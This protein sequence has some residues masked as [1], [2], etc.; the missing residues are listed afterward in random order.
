MKQITLVPVLLTNQ[1]LSRLSEEEKHFLFLITHLANE[2]S[3]LLKACL[4][5]N[6]A[7]LDEYE[8]GDVRRNAA[9]AQFYFF[10][11]ML[12]GKLYE[13]RTLVQKRYNGTTLRPR[14]E[15]NVEIGNTI[16]SI[17]SYFGPGD[18]IVQFIRHNY[19]NHNYDEGNYLLELL[20][21]VSVDCGYRFYDSENLGGRYNHASEELIIESIRHW[22]IEKHPGI[23]DVQRELLLELLNVARMFDRLSR[24]FLDACLGKILESSENE[25]QKIFE[26]LNIDVPN[27]ADIK[28][29]FF[30]ENS[31]LAETDV[32]TMRHWRVDG[33]GWG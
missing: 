5:T 11:R 29:P 26:E 25:M 30:S 3:M 7:V 18:S 2:I 24:L 12:A 21:S 4:Y 22:Y 9:I 23:S 8:L 33:F 16:H 13:G 19:A 6:A 17:N 31:T 1:H 32:S 14:Y 15:N 10:T 20:S 28:M 27:M